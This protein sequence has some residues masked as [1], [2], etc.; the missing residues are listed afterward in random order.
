[1]TQALQALQVILFGI[2]SLVLLGIGVI[3]LRHAVSIVNRRWFLAVLIPLLIA[4]T[5]TIFTDDGQLNLSWRTWLMQG[6]NI[7]LMLGSLWVTHGFQVYGL[8]I[9]AVE[10]VL[11]QVLQRQGFTV[12]ANSAEKRDLWG[13]TRD[14]CRLTAVKDEQAHVFWITARYNEVLMR[15]ERSGDSNILGQSLPTL[16]EEA[17]PY[18]FKAHAVGVL[19]IVLALVF[20][21]LTWIFF[22]EP[23]FILIE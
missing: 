9:E 6:A 2:P 11:T 16:R 22:F 3:I 14:A 19:Y 23:R 18:D 1:M 7:V 5:L 13:Q 15:A 10:Q 4:N 12:N 21:V 8:G 20:T 17:V